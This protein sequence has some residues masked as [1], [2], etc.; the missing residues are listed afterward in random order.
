MNNTTFPLSMLS[1]VNYQ[2]GS[3]VSRE[4]FRDFNITITLFAFDTGQGLSEH[5][6]PYEA[7]VTILDGIADITVGG[8][9]YKVKTGELIHM[10]SNT[11]HALKA[12]K[13]FKMILYMVKKQ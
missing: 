8:K 13:Q 1:S 5:T 10:P 6:T 3:V 12:N 4:V 11:P 2:E 9:V 7:F